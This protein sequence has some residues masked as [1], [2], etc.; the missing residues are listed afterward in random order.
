MGQASGEERGDREPDGVGAHRRGGEI[1]REKPAQGR[2]P[3]DVERRR[4]SEHTLA[5]VVDQSPAGDQVLGVAE[6]DVG[7]VEGNDVGGE[8]DVDRPAGGEGERRGDR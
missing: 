6:A 2:E 3:E 8:V 5:D 7:V 1:A 4:R